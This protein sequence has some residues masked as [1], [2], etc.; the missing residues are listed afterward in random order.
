MFAASLSLVV[1]V[2]VKGRHNVLL[3]WLPRNFSNILV[4][5]LSEEVGY[6]WSCTTGS[7]MLIFYSFWGQL[8]VRECLLIMCV[9]VWV[10]ESSYGC[11][12]TENNL[13]LHGWK[14]NNVC[15]KN[16][17][18]YAMISCK[19]KEINCIIF[20]SQNNRKQDTSQIFFFEAKSTVWS[21][22]NKY[23]TYRLTQYCTLPLRPPQA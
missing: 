19:L 3:F 14:K 5:D 13:S 23:S 22:I 11:G 9:S 2:R 7:A 15:S 16:S 4:D 17:R 18:I 12:S 10:K 20:T 1:V 8:K 6:W 21:I